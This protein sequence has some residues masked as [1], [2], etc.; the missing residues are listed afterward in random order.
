MNIPRLNPTIGVP[1]EVFPG[2]KR[3]AL[4][5]AGTATLL[6]QGFKGVTVEKGAGAAAQFTVSV[7]TNTCTETIGY[8]P[9]RT[10]SDN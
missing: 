8:D 3:V 9:L 4:T 10:V 2:E 7:V 1:K 6:K 5:P